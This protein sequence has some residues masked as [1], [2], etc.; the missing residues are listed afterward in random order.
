MYTYNL[1]KDFIDEE[2]ALDLPVGVDDFW[3]LTT[4]NYCML[5]LT[6]AEFSFEEF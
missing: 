1:H 5:N 3:L 6:F 4:P 2:N